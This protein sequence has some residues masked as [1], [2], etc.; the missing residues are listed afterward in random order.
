MSLDTD[1]R[2]YN[3]AFFFVAAA[4]CSSSS[5]T[6]CVLKCSFLILGDA[7]QLAEGRWAGTR[8]R[9]VDDGGRGPLDIVRLRKKTQ[10]KYCV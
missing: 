4:C 7:F 6:S 1:G 5:P 2:V 3:H 10:D 9:L 8:L